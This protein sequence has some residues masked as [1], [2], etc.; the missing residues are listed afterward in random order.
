M[1]VLLHSTCVG[2]VDELT[3]GAFDTKELAYDAHGTIDDG[4]ATLLHGTCVVV[5]YVDGLTE[6]AFQ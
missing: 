4:E 2:K 6:D 1:V 5:G 3:E